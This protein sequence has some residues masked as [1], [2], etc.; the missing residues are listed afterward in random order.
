MAVQ[1]RHAGIGVA[2]GRNQHMGYHSFA[3]RALTLGERL[4]MTGKRLGHTQ[5]QT[6]VRYGMLI[7][8]GTRS[9]QPL[10]GSPEASAAICRENG[11]PAKPPFPIGYRR[12]I[13]PARPDPCMGL[14]TRSPVMRVRRECREGCVPRARRPPRSDGPGRRGRGMPPHSPAPA[15]APAPHPARPYRPPR[16]RP[17]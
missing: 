14:Q 7:S 2:G 1:V 11:S 8:S 13:L 4:T 6:P 16:R 3:S 9:G 15:S 17:S 12:R 10:R 5:V